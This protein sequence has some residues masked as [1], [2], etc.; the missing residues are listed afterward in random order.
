MTRKFIPENYIHL[1]CLEVS[2]KLCIFALEG[3]KTVRQPLWADMHFFL[4][5]SLGLH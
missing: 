5:A 1:I 4:H 2:W 3:S